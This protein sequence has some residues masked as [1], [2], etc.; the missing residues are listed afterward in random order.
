MVKMD[1][2]YS[3]VRGTGLDRAL[4]VPY[5]FEQYRHLIYHLVD[6]YYKINL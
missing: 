5:F 3:R 2:I 1:K 4:Y 6:R